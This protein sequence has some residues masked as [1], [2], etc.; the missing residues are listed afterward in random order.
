VKDV[1][2]RGGVVGGAA[3]GGGRDAAVPASRHG[4]WTITIDADGT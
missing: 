4:N 2:S 3:G 1:G